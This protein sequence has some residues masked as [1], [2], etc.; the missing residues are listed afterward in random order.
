M[1]WRL[2]RATGEQLRDIDVLDLCV[3][4]RIVVRKIHGRSIEE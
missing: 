2:I 3:V 1:R 4:E